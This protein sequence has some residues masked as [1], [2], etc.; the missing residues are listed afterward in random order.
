[1]IAL[2]GMMMYLPLINA[3]DDSTWWKGYSETS[4]PSRVKVALKSSPIKTHQESYSGEN[5]WGAARYYLSDRDSLRLLE[6][7]RQLKLQRERGGCGAGS[8]GK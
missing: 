1:M 3:S 5:K 8:S 2:I 4:D 6:E 7:F